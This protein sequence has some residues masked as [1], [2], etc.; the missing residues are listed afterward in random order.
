MDKKSSSNLAQSAR[1]IS[2]NATNI[3]T[4]SRTLNSELNIP[5]PVIPPDENY[6]SHPITP[7]RSGDSSTQQTGSSA[8]NLVN[9]QHSA[10]I[11]NNINSEIKQTE[12][13]SNN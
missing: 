6:S 11:R 10:N 2:G 5:N 8:E 1:Q 9:D 13:Q 4:S 12:Q 7:L 3:T